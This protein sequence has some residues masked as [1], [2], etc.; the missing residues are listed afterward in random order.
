MPVAG[1]GRLIGEEPE[2]LGPAQRRLGHETQRLAGIH[3]F[4]KGDFFG[5]RDDPVGNLV[6]DRSACGTVHVTPGRKGVMRRLGGSVD[7][8][9]ITPCRGADYRQIDRRDR[10]KSGAG[11]SG[12]ILATNMIKDRRIIVTGEQRFGLAEVFGE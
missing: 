1:I 8:G 11:C 3:T 12:K 4:Q 10:L 6:Q 2:I 7:I 9:R 5:P